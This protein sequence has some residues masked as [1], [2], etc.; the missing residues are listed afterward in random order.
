VRAGAP[1]IGFMRVPADIILLCYRHSLNRTF[2]S[3]T[4]ALPHS[5]IR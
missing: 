3:L 2:H 1:A 5:F 4:S